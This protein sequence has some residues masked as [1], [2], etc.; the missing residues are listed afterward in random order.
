MYSN[1]EI[2]TQKIVEK[3]DE[4]DDRKEVNKI[5]LYKQIFF[6]SHKSNRKYQFKIKNNHNIITENMHVNQTTKSK[7]YIKVEKKGK[8]ASNTHLKK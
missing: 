5:N 7:L 4:D 8:N 6:E 2:Y 3:N 1:K